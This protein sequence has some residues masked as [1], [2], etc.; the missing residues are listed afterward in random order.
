MYDREWDSFNETRFISLRC[1]H[2]HHGASVVFTIV[3]AAVARHNA[4]SNQAIKLLCAA[5]YVLPIVHDAENF[6]ADG[7]D[8]PSGIVRVIVDTDGADVLGTRAD[9]PDADVTIDVAAQE[10]YCWI[11]LFIVV[12]FDV[13][14][15][16]DVLF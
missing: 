5:M 16:G 13:G 14:Y 3:V 9:V 10:V 8:K 12:E 6:G 4:G 15:I 7:E 2:A 1:P 11:S